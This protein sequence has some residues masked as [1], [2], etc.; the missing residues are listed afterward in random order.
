MRATPLLSF[1]ERAFPPVPPSDL[2]RPE[3]I[4]AND[5]VAFERLDLMKDHWDRDRWTEGYRAYYWMLTFPDDVHLVKTARRCQEALAP[6]DMDNIPD[7]GLH[8]TMT[9]IG[10]A[11]DIGRAEIGSL[12]A[13]ARSALPA[14]FVIHAHPLT[15][16]RGAARLTVTPWTPLVRLH[17]A[18]TAANERAGFPGGRPTSQFRP[19]LAIAYNNRE[20]PAVELAPFLEPMSSFSSVALRVTSIDIVELRREDA[21]YRW[22]VIHALQ[23][24]NPP[25]K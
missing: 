5:R 23:L 14:P 6:L 25:N 4:I 1:D 10:E 17:E 13:A 21:A 9:R 12:A 16:S 19:H 22:D 8:I 15:A 18:V 2:D 7:D 11:R 20:R 24:S 3:T